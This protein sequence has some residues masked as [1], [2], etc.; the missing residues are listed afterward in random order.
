MPQEDDESSV[1]H[2]IELG[3]VDPDEAAAFEAS[4]RRQ[5]HAEFKRAAELAARNKLDDAAKV[6]ELLCADDPNWPAP[7]QLLAEVHYRAARFDD[8]Q[9]QLDWLTYH[10]VESP[11]LALLAGTIALRRR[12]VA[13]AIE[14]LE[15]AAHVEPDLPSVHMLL[16]TA[17]L[18]LGRVKE[19]AGCF[20]EAVGRNVADVR[21]LDGM[22]AACLR[23]AKFDEAA[24]WSL[25]ALEGDMHLFDAHCHLGLALA[26]LNRP[27]DALRALEAGARIDPTR[28]GPYRW[29]AKIAGEQLNDPERAS[30]YIQR[31]RELTRQRRNRRRTD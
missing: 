21:A 5:Q 20:R 31:G 7:R 30:R 24:D 3:Y 19:A 28:I 18:R 8:A 29:M 14:L 16:G 1:Q 15:Y 10:G 22:A 23:L 26:G 17:L 9:S 11:R 27:E 13:L 6:L 2:L 12:E 4:R 25:R